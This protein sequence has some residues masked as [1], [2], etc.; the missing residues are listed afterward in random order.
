MDKILAPLEWHTEKIRVKDLVPCSYNP[1][2]IT[3]ERLEKLK[4]S[5]EKYNLAEIPAANTDKT[6]IAG[7]QRVKVLMDLGRGEEVID[8]RLPNRPLTESEFKE[9]NVVSNISVGYWDVDILEECFTDIDLLSLGLDINTI[10]LPDDVLPNELKQEEEQEPDVTPP[11][12]AITVFGDEYELIS[13]QKGLLHR[14][15]CGDSTQAETYKNLLQGVQFELV[16]TDPPYNVNYQGGTKEKLTIKND[17]M[18]NDD[19]YKFLYLF[20]QETFLNSKAGAPIYVFHADSEGAN[21][22][23]ALQASGY[24][25]SQCLIWVKNSFVMGRQDYHWQHEPILYGWK[26]GKTHPWYSDRKQKTI[27][28]F[29]RPLRNAD[30]PT[31]K[32][33]EII[34]YLIKNSSKQKDVIGDMFLGGGSTLISCEQTWRNCYAMELDPVYVD[35]AIRRWLKYMLDNGL[36]FEIKKNGMSLNKEQQ[37]HYLTQLS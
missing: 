27:L 4:Q 33:I 11:K 34:N 37:D 22:R 8:V 28:E 17:K 25:L 12:K 2:K 26:E 9:Y 35:V 31:M 29:D 20:Y 18:D 36:D 21:F 24:K 15:V 19:F 1:R 32:P 3:P 7:H 30:H 23:N 14:V 10:D 13:K 5:L 6:I 16:V